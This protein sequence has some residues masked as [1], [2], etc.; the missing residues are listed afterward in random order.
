MMFSFMKHR[1]DESL[2]YEE[3]VYPNNNFYVIINK[4]VGC[5]VH[6]SHAL[7]LPSH[8][9]AKAIIHPAVSSS[10]CAV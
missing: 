1:L 8:P 2:W 4:A 10:D 3:L 6:Q 5:S 9:I 7:P